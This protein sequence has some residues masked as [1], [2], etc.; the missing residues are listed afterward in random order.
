[1]ELKEERKKSDEI[2]DKF[3]NFCIFFDVFKLDAQKK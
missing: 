3:N 2:W 1:M